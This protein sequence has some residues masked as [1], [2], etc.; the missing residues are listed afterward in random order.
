MRPSVRPCVQ[1]RHLGSAG[2]NE[3]KFSTDV[4]RWI[5]KRGYLLDFRFRSSGA[6]GDGQHVPVLNVH[7]QS[8]LGHLLHTW[9]SQTWHLGVFGGPDN[10]SGLGLPP[11][12]SLG[13]VVGKPVI[14]NVV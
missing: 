6:R 8:R 7:G 5:S 9:K 13:S 11:Q 12:S 14:T 1:G 2:P 4:V 3:L 10:D